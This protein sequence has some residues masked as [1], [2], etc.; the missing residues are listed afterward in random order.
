MPTDPQAAYATVKEMLGWFGGG[1]AVVT[2]LAAYLGKLWATRTAAR[3]NA[4][5]SVQ[6]EKVK[7]EL[8]VLIE[9]QSDAMVRKREAYSKMATT[10]RVLIKVHQGSSQD[11][12]K[13]AF[14]AAYD[15]CSVWASE[16]V[17]HSLGLLFDLL[18]RK[19]A[20]PP[21]AIPE[22]ELQSAYQAA[23]LAMRKDSGFPNSTF[24]YRF[25]SF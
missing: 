17:I 12:Q 9:E 19:N 11:A 7:A 14:L 8:K 21:G 4:K 20:S 22:A 23:I 1:A 3:E 15:E 10:M 5:L 24:S 25:V 16:P 18:V 6:L 2:V 13:A